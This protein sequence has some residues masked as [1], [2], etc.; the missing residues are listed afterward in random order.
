[1]ALRKLL[2]VKE[3]MMVKQAMFENVKR[4][5]KTISRFREWIESLE[6]NVL[7]MPQ[8]FHFFKFVSSLS[9]AAATVETN[10]ATRIEKLGLT[11]VKV[12]T[13]QCDHLA[14]AVEH[15]RINPD[16]LNDFTKDEEDVGKPQEGGEAFPS[17]HI[18][19]KT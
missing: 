12:S 7:N 18:R 9:S 4:H 15:H 3:L 5:N 17:I 11:V 10:S 6:S 14:G 8:R 13:G 1:M 19:K 2:F 16:H